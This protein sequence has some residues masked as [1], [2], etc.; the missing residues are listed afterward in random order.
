MTP[1]CSG[2]HIDGA[3][4]ITG[5]ELPQRLDDVTRTGRPLAVV[6]G[7]GYRSSVSASLLGARTDL[8]VLNVLGGMSAWK[9]AGYPLTADESQP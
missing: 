8:D 9:A 1:A 5:G 3:T 7:S 6:C 2:G 4:F